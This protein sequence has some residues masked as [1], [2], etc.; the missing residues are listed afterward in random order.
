M[1]AVTGLSVRRALSLD[2]IASVVPLAVAVVV[3]SL[4]FWGQP[5]LLTVLE[6]L[7]VIVVPLLALY[8]RG[9]WPIRTVTACVFVIAPVW[10]L[11]YAPIHELSHALGAVVAGGHVT[12]IKLIPNFWEGT[13]AV[14]WVHTTGLDQPWQQ[15]A[16]TGGPYLLDVATLLVGWLVLTGHPSRRALVTGLLF[17][18]LVLRPAFDLVCET[19]GFAT[20][21]R[22][23]L[24]HLQLHLGTAGLWSLLGISIVLCAVVVAVVLRQYGDGAGRILTT[25]AGWPD[26][27]AR[28]EVVGHPR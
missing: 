22:G 9:G 3:L 4:V 11:A 2:H 5:A 28:V 8:L 14:A 23:D 15:L 20:G 21:Y 7:P 12:E 18:L 13:F 26:V 24:W 27:G 17:M 16:M 6:V 10:Y 19:V 25:D 1:T